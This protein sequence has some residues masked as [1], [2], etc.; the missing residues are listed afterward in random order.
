MSPS[1]EHEALHRVFQYDEVLF[2]RSLA[3]ILG[4]PVP[5]PVDVS[6]LNV[7]LTETRPLER[8]ADTVL[9]AKYQENG[10]LKKYILLIESQTDEKKDRRRRW[11]YYIAYLQDKYDCPVVLLVVC[12]KKETAEWAREPIMVG[13]PGLVSMT[14]TPVVLGPD[15]VPAVTTVDEA[16]QDITAAVFSALTHSRG[17]R[18]RDILEVLSAALDTIDA[19]TAGFLAE[20][21]EDG[22]GE[23]PAQSI[24]KV[25]MATVTYPY[26]SSIRSQGREEGR[27]EGRAQGEAAAV[28]R[29][30]AKR[31]IAVDDKSR[32][33]I[34]S[35][36][37]L[38]LLGTW[39]DRSLTAEQVDELFA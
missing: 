31:G 28:L 37:D 17:S 22:L 14:V 33:R 39:L 19:E 12:S 26:V 34:G 11:P 4:K 15:N 8:R 7:D 25:L 2:A 3:N 9:L 29:I 10:V 38:D 20:Y 1:S 6:V 18:A 16:S 27:E 23:T 36:T 30:L 24:W 5:A 35:C 13:L 21:I 32:E